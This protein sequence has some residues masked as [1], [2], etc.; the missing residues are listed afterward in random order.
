MKV[1]LVLQKVPG[2]RFWF[3]LEQV[4]DDEFVEVACFTSSARAA[5]FCNLFRM[6]GGNTDEV[7]M[8]VHLPQSV[9]D[10]VERKRKAGR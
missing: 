2:R 8:T 10:D 6:M 4:D 3:L 1:R 5:R 9:F 7:Q